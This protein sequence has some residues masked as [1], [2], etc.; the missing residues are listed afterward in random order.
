MV[1]NENQPRGFW[2]LAKVQS[3]I[4]GRDGKVRGATLRVS[5]ASGKSTV[6]QRPTTLLYPLEVNCC[7]M[8]NGASENEEENEVRQ[9]VETQERL[10]N[11][12]SAEKVQG[13]SASGRPRREAA[14]QAERRVRT[15]ATVMNNELD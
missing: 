11:E 3:L 2:K 9:D 14:V 15:W 4:I 5:S 7:D 8:A 10:D 1:H 12:I 6:L 13:A